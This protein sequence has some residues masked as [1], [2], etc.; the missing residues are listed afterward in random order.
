MNNDDIEAI[1][2][3][4]DDINDKSDLPI[5]KELKQ[6]TPQTEPKT[7]STSHV[8]Q[9]PFA[10]S[11]IVGK[12]LDPTLSAGDTAESRPNPP[13]P[14]CK[15]VTKKNVTITKPGITSIVGYGIPTTTLY[16]II[17]LVVVAIIL[18]VVTMKKKNDKD[19]KE[20]E[21]NVNDES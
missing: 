20:K 10:H 19:K 6:R 18:F 5:L 21:T 4:V 12:A 15:V 17:V 3:S 16:F 1:L 8:K 9:I 14:G 11:T 13:T 7:I 2:K